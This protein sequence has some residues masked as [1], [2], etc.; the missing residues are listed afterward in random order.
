[1]FYA[2][3]KKKWKYYGIDS[4]DEFNVVFEC[5]EWKIYN[6]FSDKRWET[7]LSYEE[8]EEQREFEIKTYAKSLTEEDITNLVEKVN[9]IT[10]ELE[11][12]KYEIVHGLE[13]IVDELS[14]DKDKLCHFAKVFV[15][16]GDFIELHPYSLIKN[17]IA[18]YGSEYV[19]NLI[20]SKEF[21]QKTDGNLN[22][23]KYCQRK[24]LIL[25]G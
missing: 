10:F 3:I 18:Q 5:E 14:S 16:K 13:I 15:E 9:Q 24:K 4:T 21:V 2:K 8:A 25:R 6:V 1:M 22:F 23:L 17:L 7:E 12:E 11:R 19:Y 20:W